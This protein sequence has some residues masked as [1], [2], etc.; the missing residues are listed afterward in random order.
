[1]GEE[2]LRRCGSVVSVLRATTADGKV[3]LNWDARRW[4]HSCL[5][6]GIERRR[7]HEMLSR[8]DAGATRLHRGI[9]I[10]SVDTLRGVLV[11]T[12]G[13]RFRTFDLAL[14]GATCLVQA[15]DRHCKLDDALREYERRQRALAV[16]YQR[17]SRWITPLF[18]SQGRVPQWLRE[19]VMP[20]LA[21]LAVVERG[22]LAWLCNSME[23]E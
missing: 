11:D 20:R 14:A 16:S 15:L 4:G 6:L 7:L 23:A 22:L 21:G 10:A 18:Q 8:A 3:L 19:R 13:E 5:G 17:H 9:E 12:R 2:E 1:M